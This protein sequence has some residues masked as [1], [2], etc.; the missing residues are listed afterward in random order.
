MSNLLRIGSAVP[1]TQ[2]RRRSSGAACLR[3]CLCPRRGG[4]QR[5]AI[6]VLEALQR[7]V[8]CHGAR[9][10]LRARWRT[11]R[12]AHRLLIEMALET[13]AAS[14]RGGGG[15]IR[16]GVT[17]HSDLLPA[18][19]QRVFDALRQALERHA[20][21]G[22]YGITCLARGADQLFAR[23]ILSLGGRYDVILPAP[24]YREAVVKPGNLA[25]FDMLIAQAGDVRFMPFE[26]SGRQAYLAASEALVTR[27]DRLLAV[28]DGKPAGGLGG[29]ADVVAHARDVGVPVDVIWPAGTQRRSAVGR[30]SR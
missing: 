15:V 24:D 27:S 9:P 8:A 26:T 1:R 28:W 16:I 22:L 18:S 25:D 29:T 12:L 20:D 3:L 19:T 10:S 7:A 4:I 14:R 2:Q 23:A 30:A 13:E 5:A 17:G 6:A 11:A 21:D